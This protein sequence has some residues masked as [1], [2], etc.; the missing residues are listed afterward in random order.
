MTYRICLVLFFRDN[1]ISSGFVITEKYQQLQFLSL[2]K[3]YNQISAY[4]LIMVAISACFVLFIQFHNILVYVLLKS[5]II[6][7]F[8]NNE[9]HTLSIFNVPFQNSKNK[10]FFKF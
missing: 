4:F 10:K 9:L 6:T 7:C 2:L 1:K 3:Q 8:F 5:K